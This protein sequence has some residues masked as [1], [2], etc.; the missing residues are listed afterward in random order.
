MLIVNKTS[1]IIHKIFMPYSTNAQKT[2][3]LQFCEGKKNKYKK[4]ICQYKN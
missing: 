3:Q 1:K 2:G 4:Q